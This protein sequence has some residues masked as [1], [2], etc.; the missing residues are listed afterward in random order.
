L[1]ESNSKKQVVNTVI[2]LLFFM[3]KDPSALCPSFG[4]LQMSTS[5]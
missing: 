2:D 4:L 5:W 3:K 1:L